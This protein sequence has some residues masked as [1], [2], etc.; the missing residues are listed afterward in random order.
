MAIRLYQ[1]WGH[2]RCAASSR[3]TLHCII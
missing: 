2:V 1:S 3:C